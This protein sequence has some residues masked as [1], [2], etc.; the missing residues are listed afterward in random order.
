MNLGQKKI[1]AALD[2]SNQD[3]VLRVQPHLQPGNLALIKTEQSQPVDKAVSRSLAQRCDLTHV[4]CNADAKLV[5]ESGRDEVRR[6]DSESIAGGSGKASD[7][8]SA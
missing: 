7:G 6:A 8:V 2:R 3:R 1:R 4:W 5:Q